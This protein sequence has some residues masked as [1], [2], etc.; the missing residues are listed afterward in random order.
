MKV[1][2][3]SC[4]A[5]IGEY[6][7]KHGCIHKLGKGGSSVLKKQKIG[8]VTAQNQSVS[9]TPEKI[10]KA[11]LI[12]WAKECDNRNWL[13]MKKDLVSDGM[14]DFAEDIEKLAHIAVAKTRAECEKEKA[15]EFVT[16]SKTADTLIEQARKEEQEVWAQ[17][18]MRLINFYKRELKKVKKKPLEKILKEIEK[19]FDMQYA[20]S[21]PE[22]CDCW[23]KFKERLEGD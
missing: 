2:Y 22:W 17:Q 13:K 23:E 15:D 6:C 1:K 10:E 18:E 16:L 4:T 19:K 9:S 20:C 7:S 11:V 21:C 5:P 14:A 8:H 3:K 12:E